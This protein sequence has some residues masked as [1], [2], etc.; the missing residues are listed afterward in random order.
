M[1]ME[2]DTLGNGRA[3][4]MSL[5]HCERCPRPPRANKGLNK[6]GLCGRKLVIERKLFLHIVRQP[7]MKIDGV[8][9]TLGS[10][11]ARPNKRGT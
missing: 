3:H 6:K 7:V 1:E 10:G 9:S 8:V 2:K 11:T 5:L 4:L